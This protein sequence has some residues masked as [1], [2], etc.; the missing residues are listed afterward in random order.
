MKKEFQA[1]SIQDLDP[2]VEYIVELISNYR[3]FTFQGDLGS[4]KTTLIK[5][6][7]DRIGV[8]DNVN[9]PTFSIINEYAQ[10]GN[11]IYHFDLYRIIESSE[12]LNIGVE[13]YFLSNQLC[14]VEWP[15]IGEEFFP[16]IRVS[17]LITLEK[18]QRMVSI[19]FPNQHL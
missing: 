7:C 4:G 6:I 8:R 17:I 1:K 18:G 16:N 3:F 12:L 2:I 11:A 19:S 10:N 13:D 5:K 9:S 15:S 14:F